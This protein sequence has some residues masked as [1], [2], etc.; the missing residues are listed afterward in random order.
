MV[1]KEMKQILNSD[2]LIKFDI[3]GKSKNGM[4]YCNIIMTRILLEGAKQ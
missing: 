1:L 2:K 3:I 4:S